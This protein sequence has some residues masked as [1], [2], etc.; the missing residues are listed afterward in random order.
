MA[1]EVYIADKATLD[2][3]NS[4]VGT[5]ADDSAMV[6]LFGK[7]EKING[8]LP[9]LSGAEGDVVISTNTTL[10]ITDPA[11]VYEI[12][13]RNFTL[14]AGVTLTL[15]ACR[16]FVIRATGTI[17][18]KGSIDGG[19]KA[20]GLPTSASSQ[21]VLPNGAIVNFGAPGTLGGGGG[22]QGSSGG[23]SGGSGASGVGVAGVAQPA[24]PNNGAPGYGGGGGS[25]GSSNT[26]GQTGSGGG[27][28]VGIFTPALTNTGI[29]N[30]SGS[31]AS[32]PRAGGA[33][34]IL[35]A[36]KN[37]NI[38]GTIDVRGGSGTTT[39]GGAGSVGVFKL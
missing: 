19:G 4:K 23:T 9:F 11:Q 5:S 18:I 13:C 26:G 36:L 24:G 37:I 33:G 7:L 12:D 20:H 34:I 31:G 10:S 21:Y 8:K 2:A 15:P 25:G 28:F 27:G 16:G 35:F 1:G 22:G 30:V 39:L 6:S 14:N 32:T 3:V 38:S 29:V 17:D